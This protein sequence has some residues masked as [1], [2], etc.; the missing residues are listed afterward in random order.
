MSFNL[1][2]IH[3][4]LFNKILF[5]NKLTDLLINRFNLSENL[6]EIKNLNGLRLENNIDKDNIHGSLQGMIDIVEKRYAITVNL[7]LKDNT[8]EEIL[9]VV[10]R[11]GMEN[12]ISNSNVMEAFNI[13]NSK[14]LNG[15]PCDRVINIIE[16]N[17]SR[18]IWEEN[19]M[20][21]KRYWNDKNYKVYYIIRNSL[22]KSMLYCLK[23]K[24]IEEG[25]YEISKR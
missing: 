23:F 7:I 14:L 21:H 8:I 10:N 17:S 9:S 20:I 11:Y 22:I 13:L 5:Q 19:N 18:I 2:P 6:A 3:Y 1:G 4:Q 15:M 16:Q 24:E 12:R 25:V